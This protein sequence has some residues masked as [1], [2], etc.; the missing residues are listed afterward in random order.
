MQIRDF[1][2]AGK[3]EPWIIKEGLMG[4]AKKRVQPNFYLCAPTTQSRPKTH[5][6][7]IAAAVIKKLYIY[8][9][10]PFFVS[11]TPFQ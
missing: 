7:H 8:E 4:E 6:D 11:L 2:R 3:N 5:F 9:E 10:D 1:K